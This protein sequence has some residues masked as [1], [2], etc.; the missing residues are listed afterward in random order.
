MAH[1]AKIFRN[2]GSQAVRL[3]KTCRFPE[4]QSEVI[5]RRVGRQVILEPV[6]EWPA[7][8]LGS[9]GAWSDNIER[10]LQKAIGAVRNR[11]EA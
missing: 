4:G 8:F 5:V 9:L 10:P 6:D 11:L 3:P 2:G 1:R 7:E